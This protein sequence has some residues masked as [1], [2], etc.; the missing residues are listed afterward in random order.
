MMHPCN[1][2]T[3]VSLVYQGDTAIDCGYDLHYGYGYSYEL[4]RQLGPAC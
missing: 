1:L 4:H 2:F 3:I